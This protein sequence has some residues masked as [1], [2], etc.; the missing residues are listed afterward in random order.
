MKGCV[1]KVPTKSEVGVIKI[2][3]DPI[4]KSPLKF[5]ISP[6]IGG[7]GSGIMETC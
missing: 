3:N 6:E 1:S 5:G 4:N 7:E 2:R